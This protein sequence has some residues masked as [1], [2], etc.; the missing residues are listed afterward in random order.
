MIY[1]GPFL[2]LKEHVITVFIRSIDYQS[3]MSTHLQTHLLPFK[4]ANLECS[5]LVAFV[6][7]HHHLVEMYNLF[8]IAG[9][10]LHLASIVILLLKMTSQRNC[11]GE[12]H[13]TNRTII[14]INII[15]MHDVISFHY[16]TMAFFVSDG[17]MVMMNMNRYIIKDTV[18]LLSCICDTIS[19]YGL[20]FL[21][22][23]PSL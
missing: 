23:L 14:N 20:V 7:H 8:R 21:E 17:G 22:L 16:Q 10:L 11:R 3:H 13:A 2:L 19:W 5:L 1:V 15:H 9:D 12:L 4:L 18:S 6:Q